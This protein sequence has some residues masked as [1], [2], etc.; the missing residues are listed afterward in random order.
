[1]LHYKSDLLK[2]MSKVKN[3]QMKQFEYE[4]VAERLNDKKFLVFGTGYDTEFWRVCNSNGLTVFLEHDPKWVLNKNND[5][6]LIEYTTVLSQ[7]NNLL[8][9]YRNKN[10]KNL[11]IKL[12]EF[13]YEIKWDAIFVDGPPGNKNNSIGRMQ[14]IY[15]AFE[16]SNNDTDIFI[17]DCDRTVEDLYSREFFKIVKQLDKLRHCKK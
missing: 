9:E 11:Q 6:Y 4:Y 17:H 8:N 13:L 2:L 3:G 14:S 16:L 15:M 7:Y 5:T 1:M 10:F 12:P